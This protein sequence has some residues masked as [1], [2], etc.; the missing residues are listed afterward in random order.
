MPPDAARFLELGS[1]PIRPE[2]PGQ[3]DEGAG[4]L[5]RQY[6]LGRRPCLL[7]QLDG[8]DRIG[9]LAREFSPLSRPFELNK[10]CMVTEGSAPFDAAG[11]RP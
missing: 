3:K 10:P 4:D 9:N 2:D 11:T 1:G 8:L 5:V 6:D 7:V